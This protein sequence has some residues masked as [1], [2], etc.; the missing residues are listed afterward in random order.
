VKQQPG[1]G[2]GLVAMI[3]FQKG[4]IVTQY[5]GFIINR[6]E[7]DAMGCEATHVYSVGKMAID[8]LRDKDEAKGFGG[9]SFANHSDS[10][11]CVYIHDVCGRV[12]LKAT[13]MI[14]KGE[15]I[16]VR[17]GSKYIKNKCLFTP[18][19]AE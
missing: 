6:G 10:P 3:P 12:F 17:Y 18:L 8:G 2:L 4:K 7:A 16:T 19:K 15:F 9:G 1:M 13:K 14:E 11:N 5:E